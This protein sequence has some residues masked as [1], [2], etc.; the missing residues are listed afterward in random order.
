MKKFLKI[1]TLLSVS[2]MW[3]F[4]S[5]VADITNGEIVQKVKQYCEQ[6]GR[7]DAVGSTC[8]LI[9]SALQSNNPAD[10]QASYLKQVLNVPNNDAIQTKISAGG[11]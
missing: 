9:Y 2:S 6:N 3:V 4:F 5:A 10:A 8:N 7:K 1:A 11:L